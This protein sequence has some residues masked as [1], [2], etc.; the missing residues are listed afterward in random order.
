MRRRLK[1]QAAEKTFRPSGGR[2]LLCCA[3]NVTNQGLAERSEVRG[4]GGGVT[5]KT[6]CKRTIKL[7][8]YT[9]E[10]SNSSRNRG[11]LCGGPGRNMR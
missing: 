9:G 10:K 5:N 1:G 3:C 6:S 8:G 11:V 7:A 4:K 2:R